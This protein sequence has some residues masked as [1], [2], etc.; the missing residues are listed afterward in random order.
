MSADNM[1]FFFLVG[2]LFICIYF[3]N[4]VLGNANGKAP[5]ESNSSLIQVAVAL[6][7]V[8]ALISSGSVDIGG[9]VNGFTGAA[10]SAGVPIH[11]QNAPVPEGYQLVPIQPA[12]SILGP[13]EQT[14]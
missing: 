6:V 10:N 1:T 7:V 9:L 11:P 8:L 2:G 4:G 13:L 14:G 5:A 3:S 12:P